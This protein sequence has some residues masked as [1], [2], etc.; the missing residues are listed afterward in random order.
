MVAVLA[1]VPRQFV[2]AVVGQGSGLSGIVRATMGGVLLDLCS[3]GILMVAAKLYERGVSAGQVI[4][5]LVASPWNSFSLTLLLVA[6]MGLQWT[7]VFI[8][9]SL[10]IAIVSGL[11]FNWLVE[12]G[13]LP[14]NPHSV[15]AADGFRFWHD[16]YSGLRSVR[17]ELRNL[18]TFVADGFFSARPVLRWIL[19]GI[20]LAALVRATL[21]PS[22]LGTY[23]G[24]TLA[25]LG[26]TIIVATIIEV[27]SEGS[28]PIGADLV[29]RAEAPGNGF[30]FLM[31]GVAT[32]YTEIMILKETTDSWKFAL[33][34]PFVCVPQVII[35]SL[36][37]N[38]L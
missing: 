35:I 18:P 21:D 20:L 6:M 1:K 25:G 10:G 15:P 14:A 11:A 37:L 27:C 34:L 17:L 23:F 36:L 32:D 29:T 7:L 16:A 8:G 2:V 5:F 30:A 19:F 13:S 12:R 33:F 31:T 4:A 28:A 26:L 3:H 9:L 24:P 38:W 22:T